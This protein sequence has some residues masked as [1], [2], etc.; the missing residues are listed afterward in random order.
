MRVLA[1]DLATCTGYAIGAITDGVIEHGSHR[2]PKTGEDV[3]LYLIH[4]RD[5]LDQLIA[6]VKPTELIFESPVLFGAKTN[7]ATLRKLYSL[8]GVTEMVAFEAGLP[9][10]EENVQTITTHFLSKGCPRTGDARKQATIAKCR[11]RGWNP[12]DENDADALALL[13]LALALKQPGFAMKATP[14]FGGTA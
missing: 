12:R 5:W 8:A 2:I 14:L 13:D 6:R 4:H 1:L 10:T 3:G 7:L 11:E 9:V